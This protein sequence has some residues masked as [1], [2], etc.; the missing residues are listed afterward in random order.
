MLKND[1]PSSTPLNGAVKDCALS[2]TRASVRT[3]MR[4]WAGAARAACGKG[5]TRQ[6]DASRGGQG[7]FPRSPCPEG[8]QWVSQPHRFPRARLSRAHKPPDPPA[9]S[10]LARI[11][12][13]NRFL[14]AWVRVGKSRN[15]YLN[16]PQVPVGR[17]VI[18]DGTK[19]PRP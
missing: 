15:E 4:R 11:A 18:R 14:G 12:A 9:G 3:K 5:F 16:F 17:A 7:D 8:R 10:G 6:G 2:D 1:K 13:A 19:K